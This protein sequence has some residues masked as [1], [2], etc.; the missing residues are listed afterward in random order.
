MVR[1]DPTVVGGELHHDVH[2]VVAVGGQSV[3][4]GEPRDAL[5]VVTVDDVH[6]R[7]TVA[8]DGLPFLVGQD[9]LPGLDGERAV[10]HA[11]PAML[12]FGVVLASYIGRERVLLA[13]PHTVPAVEPAPYLLIRHGLQ[14]LFIERAFHVPAGADEM[15]VRV[16]VVPALAEQVADESCGVRASDDVW[17]H[18]PI[19][20]WLKLAYGA[21]RLR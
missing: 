3:T 14:T 19:L 1:V 6:A 20:S 17:N 4:D 5:I 21:W 18:V 9:S 13:F 10:P 12:S 8:D 16:L 15:L 11:L 7:Q 2:V